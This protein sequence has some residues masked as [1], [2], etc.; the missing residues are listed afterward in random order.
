MRKHRGTPFW[1]DKHVTLAAISPPGLAR[2]SLVGGHQSGL[3]GCK[4]PPLFT[5]ETSSCSS[6]GQ[7]QG[8]PWGASLLPSAPTY[9]PGCGAFG[10]GPSPTRNRSSSGRA[11]GAR[12]PV[13]VSAGGVGVGTRQV[14]HSA[15]SCELAFRAVGAA[16]GHPGGGASCLA[17]GRPGLGAL[18]RATA[19][20]LGVRPGSATDWLCV[21]GVWARG[22]ATYPTARAL[23]SWLCALWGPHRGPPEGRLLPGCGASRAGRSPTRDRSSSGRAAGARYPLAVG[24]GGVGVGT[25]KVPQSVRSCELALRAV[26][27]ARGRSGGGGLLPGCGA[28]GVGCFPTPNRSPLGRVAW[29]KYP[30]A[31]SAGGEGEGTGHLPHSARSC[32]LALPAVG[33]APGCPG[34]APPT[35]LWG[36]RGWTLSHTGPLVLGACGRAPLPTGC[37]CGGCA[38][39]DPPPAPQR[40]HL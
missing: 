39:G 1:R 20:R 14:P 2:G 18:P 38:R 22:P 34:G 29:A 23:A 11:A 4:P 3:A 17:V 21:R 8:E 25:R 16:R 37:G 36:V 10:V 33:A 12:Y 15:R 40:A 27:A 32:E 28:S 30:L 13:A 9:L 5:R 31:V 19:R 6:Q 7:H 24:A 35:W 26:G